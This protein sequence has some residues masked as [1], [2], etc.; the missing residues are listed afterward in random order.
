MINFFRKIRQNSIKNNKSI[1]YLK[2]A[3]GEIL[4]VMIG[5]LL[6]LQVNTWNEAQKQKNTLNAIYLI[7]KEDLIN[8][9]IE[10]DS[11]IEQ[12]DEIRKPAFET[13]LKTKTTKEDWLKNPQYETVLRGWKDFTINQRGFELLKS[14]S[15]LSE[16]NEQTLA[17]KINFFYNKHIAEINIAVEELSTEF[18]TN[19]E[20]FK[21]Y[22]WF[23]SYYLN[24]EIDGL[25]EF[26][27]DNPI[28][29]NRITWY[30]LVFSIYV[31]ELK[32]FRT[33]AKELI[34]QIDYHIKEN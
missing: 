20:N 34:M 1:N 6:A 7:T 24:G 26:I 12:Y 11:F 19:N 22:P 14:Q 10:I 2:Y 5:I 18:T 21:N 32:N 33:N 31:E 25:I 15:N 3:V 30:N 4:L 17:S 23:S 9:F 16:K 13:I 8:D 27:S 28:A 29:K